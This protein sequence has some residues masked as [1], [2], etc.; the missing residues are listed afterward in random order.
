MN[1]QTNNETSYPDN[2]GIPQFSTFHFALSTLTMA[3]TAPTQ[4]PIIKPRL[5]HLK[6][7]FSNL[8]RI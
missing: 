4:K 6:I 7:R 8:F 3:T 1:S 2:I 5:E